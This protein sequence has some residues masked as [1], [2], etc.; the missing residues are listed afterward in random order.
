MKRAH[1][2]SYSSGDFGWNCRLEHPTS[3][4]VAHTIA[5][6]RPL[7]EAAEAESKRGRWVA[8]GLTYEAAPAFDAAFAVHHSTLPFACAAV[9]P[10]TEVSPPIQTRASGDFVLGSWTPTVSRETYF[11]NLRRIQ[12]YIREGD[13]YQVNYTFGQ[14]AHFVGDSEAW[15]RTL[16]A[17]QGAGYSAYLD[18]GAY[19][20]LSLSPEL[21][22]QR[23]GNR[24][25]A[26]PMKGTARTGAT[27]EET[28]RRADTLRHS[29][30]DLAENLMIV[31]LLR[32]DLSRVARLGTVSATELFTIEHYP[33][34][35]Q[36]TSTVSAECPEETTLWQV[37]QALFPCG[38]VTG[39]PKVRTME[40]I[41]ELET[42]PRGIYCGAIGYVAPGGDCVF[43]VPIR[44]VLVD[45]L[46]ERAMFS[47][48]SGIT[49]GSD[50]AAEYRECLLKSRFLKAPNS[51]F[52]SRS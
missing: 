4:H 48:G 42:S 9:F 16:C 32:N 21:F 44:T 10:S 30:K 12:S 49:D 18:F 6:V 26:R 19:Q 28:R 41:N 39:A 7:V 22:F 3:V 13:T 27:P 8:L 34:V 29:T 31:D 33:T 52:S 5:D 23:S 2:E 25:I 37:L 11:A 40:I 47:T 36:M 20:I 45:R 17:Q 24:L 14:T 15:Y 43:N 51:S 1:F 38:S 50:T 35:L 46:A